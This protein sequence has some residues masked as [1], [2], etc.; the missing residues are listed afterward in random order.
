MVSQITSSPDINII[1]P[2]QSSGEASVVQKPVSIEQKDTFEK[3]EKTKSHKLGMAIAG[4]VVGTGLGIILFMGGHKGLRKTIK[5]VEKKSAEL[6]KKHRT[7]TGAERFGLNIL[8]KIKEYKGFANSALNAAS[9]KDIGTKKL[10]TDKI[11]FLKVAGDYVSSIFEKI[12]IHS[13]QKSYLKASKQLGNLYTKLDEVDARIP[14]EKLSKIKSALAEFD[15]SFNKT[16]GQKAVGER[17]RQMNKSLDGFGD[18]FWNET[19][20]SPGR[21]ITNKHSYNTFLADELAQPTK[22]KLADNVIE[23]TNRRKDE[24][25]AIIE[26][27]KDAGL[28]EKEMKGIQKAYTKTLK[29]LDKSTDIETDKL[30]DKL[31]DIKLGS[32]PTDFLGVIGAFGAAGWGLAKSENKDERI[33]ASLQYGIPAIGAVSISLLCTTSLISAGPALII[34]TASGIAISKLG[35]FLDKKRKHFNQAATVSDG[36]KRLL[37]TLDK[38]TE[39]ASNKSSL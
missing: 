37:P 32:A 12:S 5:A 3:K 39:S 11:P 6:T 21:L 20:H 7:L 10:I 27:Y 25:K 4:S 36:V 35:E 2:K 16:H 24:L 26:L 14:A 29:F 22:M 33:S 34:G 31:R 1:K 38:K 13:A 17:L 8:N 19:L 15:L 18:T 28:S 9:Y 30:F 23:M